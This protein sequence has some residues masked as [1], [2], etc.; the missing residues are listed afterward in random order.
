MGAIADIFRQYGDAYIQHF[1]QGIPN[2]HRK[3]IRSIQSCRTIEQGINCYTCEGCGKVHH[4]YKGCGSRNCPNCQQHKGEE[5]LNKRMNDRLPGHHFMITFTIPQE[6]RDFV[7][8]AQKDAYDAMFEASSASLKALAAD[9]RFVGADLSG[10]FGVLHT[11]GRQLHYHPHIHYIVPGGGIDK[12]TKT[13]QSSRADFFVS[14]H[15]LSK[16]FRGKLRAI[17]KRK[18]LL[19]YIDPSIWQ[20]PF[21][22]N[23]QA[24]GNNAEGAIKYLAPYVFRMAISDSRIVSIKNDRVTF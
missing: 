4:V 7:R 8:S 20:K 9:P 11:W 14:I 13:W 2:A 6:L 18:D 22:V 19:Q 21:I 10:F 16:M 15:A 17:L 1:D 12:K 23:S 24:C 3:A 5:W